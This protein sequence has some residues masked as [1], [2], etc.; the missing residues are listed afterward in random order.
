MA[1]KSAGYAARGSLIA[2]KIHGFMSTPKHQSL[3]YKAALVFAMVLLL[4][5]TTYAGFHVS[6]AYSTDSN[7]II[8]TYQ[9]GKGM[10]L[11]VTL[12]GPHATLIVIPLLL[13][14]G[15]LPYHYT[16][17]TLLNVG[18]VLVTMIAWAFLLIKLFGRKYEIP[19]LILLS[20][21]VF[22]SV[23]FSLTLGY[24]TIRNIEYPIVLW[25]VLIVGRVLKN[26]RYSRR[27]LVLAA[28]G[29]L[30][31]VITLAGDSFFNYAIL[32]P[33]LAVIA[34]YWVQSRKFTANMVKAVGLLAGVVIGAALLKFI[35]GA[36]GIINF[37]YAF[38]GPNTIIP[39]SSL[40]PS[41]SVAL[42]QVMDLQGGAIFGQVVN[43]H[44]LALFVNFGLLIVSVVSLVLILV[45]SSLSYRKKAG[46]DDDNNFVFVSMAVSYFVVFFI[47]AL[48]GYAITTL[49]NGQIIS[50]QNT[51]YISF[52]PLISTIG[53]VW[54][55]KNYYKDHKAFL[56]IVCVVLV[57]GIATSYSGVSTAYRSGTNQLELVP[58]R[59]SVDSV[60]ST[61]RS[62]DVHE[63]LT[64]YWYGPVIRFWSNNSINLA[65]ELGCNP[66]S[67]SA[68][69]P[70]QFVR[71]KGIKT[72]LIIDRG[73][74]NYAYWACSDPQLLQ[75]YGTP[76]KELTV[77]GVTP[78]TPVE[79]WIYNN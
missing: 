14:Q 78:S 64:D 23:T 52:M 69:Q 60:I 10:Q 71:R 45:K 40:A 47:Y 38:W 27:E 49:A 29:S 8:T 77:E 65:Q 33:L 34:W 66:S 61:L 62:N 53:L 4:A 19:I 15:H 75:L 31:F 39:T 21:L 17:F 67:L 26:L 37:N 1:K 35:L 72:A 13:I 5:T 32:L 79:I 36:A 2:K 11:P 76:S 54:L 57:L 30:L 46:L 59:S 51:R 68:T 28:I 44:N 7:A 20:S 58:P 74:L 55:V 22:T 24:T 73:G 25:F 6:D 42:K 48:S 9:F 3:A 56:S 41:M 12:P 18:L 16:S 43:Y 50:D 70:D 63:V